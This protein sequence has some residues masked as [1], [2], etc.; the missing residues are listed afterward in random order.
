ML[1]SQ[2]GYEPGE[3]IRVMVRTDRSD[4]LQADTRFELMAPDGKPIHEGKV[5]A[6]GE[7]WGAH[8]WRIEVP[9]S[10]QPGEYRIHLL[11]GPDQHITS[12]PISIQP[13]TRWNQC[14]ETIAFDFLETRAKLARTGK[15]WKDCGSDLQELSSHVVTIDSLCDILEKCPDLTDATRKQRITTQIVR[16][17]EYVAMLQDRARE[18]DLGDGPVVHESRQTDLTTGNIIKA[19]MIFA[20]CSRLLKESNPRLAEDYLSRS[21]RAYRWI[22]EKGPIIPT[23]EPI[24]FAPVHGAPKG[25]RPPVG[26]WMTRD[27]L[28]LTRAA[29][30]LH[31][32]GLSEFQEHAHRHARAVMKRQISKADAEGGFYGH[33]WLYDDFSSFGGTKFSE[34]AVIH[35]GAWSKEGRIYHKGGHYPHHLIPLIEMLNLWPNHSDA[36]A[37]KQCIRDFAYG[38]FL[39]ACRTS[40]F[41][42]LPNGYYHGAG[43]QHFGSWYHGQSSMY[44]L[45]A[46]LALEFEHLFKE[47]VFH[48]LAV[49]NVQW[50]AGLN[51]GWSKERGGPILAYSMVEG[52]GHRSWK[53][54]SGIKGSTI[55]GFSASP[56]FKIHAVDAAKDQPAFF[57]NED[58]IA[59]SLPLLSAC[60][61]LE[62]LR[63]MGIRN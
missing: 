35:C 47:P 15:G 38:Y 52:I 41:L 37:W 27:L 36:P 29:L 21:L 40:P 50:V 20:R 32:A 4:E 42:I 30:E 14:F 62:S 18:L 9:K 28:M 19:A 63:R 59:H 12:D 13:G 1:S 11:H 34:K 49:A 58:Y 3:P 44:S 33:F 22:T 57:D 53:G 51:C 46:I 39:P 8:W 10:T 25:S 24:F 61:R 17:M 43:I 7:K 16:G 26:Q 23:E 54:W 55:N 5:M 45:A 56:Q 2:I 60:A 6:A 31:K 48:D